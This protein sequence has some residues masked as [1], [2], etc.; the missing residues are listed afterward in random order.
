MARIERPRSFDVN[1]PPA[2]LTYDEVR[3]SFL[4]RL[5]RER[6]DL[7]TFSHALKSAGPTTAVEYRNL[8]GFAHRL[9][10]AAAVFGF[11]GVRDCAKVLEFAAKA[12]LLEN[13]PADE[14]PIQNAARDL[15]AQLTRAI[16]G[17]Q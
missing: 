5:Q 14:P 4:M 15:H 10:G 11:E 13:A 12:A 16:G 6:S 2:D 3:Q 17:T 1:S 8:E 9:R 7:E